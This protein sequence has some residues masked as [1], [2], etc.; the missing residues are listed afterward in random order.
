MYNFP[1][2][3]RIVFGLNNLKLSSKRKTVPAQFWTTC[4]RP[5]VEQNNTRKWI[6]VSYHIETVYDYINHSAFVLVIARIKSFWFKTKKNIDWCNFVQ[7]DKKQKLISLCV[8]QTVENWSGMPSATHKLK[9][10]INNNAYNKSPWSRRHDLKFYRKYFGVVPYDIIALEMI[11]VICTITSCVPPHF[12]ASLV[13]LNFCAPVCT[14]F[15]VE[16][17]QIRWIIV[18]LVA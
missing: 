5:C 8:T 6:S 15:G 18:S 7:L 2:W 14:T 12:G 16:L 9:F 13:Y 10:H 4:A 1:G 11:F 17:V 3:D